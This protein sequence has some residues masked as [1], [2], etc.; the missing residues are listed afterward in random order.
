MK[1]TKK[2][3]FFLESVKKQLNLDLKVI[4]QRAENLYEKQDIVLARALSPLKQYSGT[5]KKSCWKGYKNY[6]SQR[7]CMARRNKGIKKQVE[8]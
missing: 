6:P 7:R 5:I 2:N 4:N 8:I 1:L 3:V